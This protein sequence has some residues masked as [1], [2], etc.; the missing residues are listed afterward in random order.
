MI[1]EL[2]PAMI[3]E[4]VSLLN[5]ADKRNQEW[6]DKFRAEKGYGQQ[7]VIDTVR[8]FHDTIRKQLEAAK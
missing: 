8:H 4:L 6:E 3:K 2:Q 5:D 1:V 7:H